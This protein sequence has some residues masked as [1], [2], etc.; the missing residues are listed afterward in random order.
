MKQKNVI[1]N[2]FRDLMIHWKGL[3]IATLLLACSASAQTTNDKRLNMLRDS[4]PKGWEMEAQVQPFGEDDMPTLFL[5]ISRVDSVKQLDINKINMDVASGESLQERAKQE[6]VPT[7]LHLTMKL[8]PK[9]SKAKLDKVLAYDDSLD[10]E[11]KEL[12][13]KYNIAELEKPHPLGK[14]AYVY[15]ESTPEKKQRLA[16]YTE[17]SDRLRALKKP[18]PAYSSSSYSVFFYP[19]YTASQFREIYPAQAETEEYQVIQLVSRILK[20]D[21]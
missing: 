21:F 18:W 20:P 3:L 1:P 9:W 12:Y 19:D 5:F 8:E 6:G 13:I 16:A 4:L 7:K 10:A 2:L 15:D 14:G 11:I 17:Q